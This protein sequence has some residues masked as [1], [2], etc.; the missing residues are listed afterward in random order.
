M[1]ENVK[2]FLSFA[3]DHFGN[4]ELVSTEQS[5]AISRTISVLSFHNPVELQL[6]LPLTTETL[7]AIEKSGKLSEEQIFIANQ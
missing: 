6:D 1:A 5:S 2:D 7:Q 4:L 3:R